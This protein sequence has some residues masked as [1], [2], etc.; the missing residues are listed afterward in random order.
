MPSAR[1]F[2][3][4]LLISTHPM[5]GAQKLLPTEPIN[6]VPLCYVSGVYWSNKGL[7]YGLHNEDPTVL[8][9]HLEA[10]VQGNCGDN[11]AYTLALDDTQFD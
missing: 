9:L 10:S 4:N 11:V 5:N 3:A 1:Q 7:K 6:Y 8:S 2:S